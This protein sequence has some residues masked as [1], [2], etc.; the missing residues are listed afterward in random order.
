MCPAPTHVCAALLQQ[1]WL[2]GV[3]NRGCRGGASGCCS[4]T[5]QHLPG[6]HCA[7]RSRPPALP[8]CRQQQQ[9]WPEG[10][11][12]GL[13]LTAGDS[14]LSDAQALTCQSVRLG[15]VLLHEL[16]AVWPGRVQ[17]LHGLLGA[18]GRGAGLEGIRD[19]VAA[20]A[21]HARCAAAALAGTDD[22]LML[23]GGATVCCLGWCGG[24]ADSMQWHWA[25][26]RHPASLDGPASRPVPGAQ[27]CVPPQLQHCP[28]EP[29]SPHTTRPPTPLLSP[30]PTRSRAPDQNARRWRG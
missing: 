30:H 21:K 4:V 11:M 20:S 26:V 18:T 22:T 9:G 8:H 12:E 17:L 28:E 7:C 29:T 10:N 2:A 5:Q 24:G 19:C 25:H 14:W 23:C 16:A 13:R 3:A 27:A 1:Q 6:G 15:I